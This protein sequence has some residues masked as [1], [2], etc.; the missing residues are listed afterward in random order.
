[1]KGCI[2]EANLEMVRVVNN[3]VHHFIGSSLGV[4]IFLKKREHEK[5]GALK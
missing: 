4:E 1:M 3:T 2:P 5:K